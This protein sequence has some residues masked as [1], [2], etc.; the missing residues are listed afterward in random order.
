MNKK[1]EKKKDRQRTNNGDA[2]PQEQQIGHGA[3]ADLDPDYDIFIAESVYPEADQLFRFLPKPFTEI[4]E[5]CLVVLD[6][7]ALLVPYQIGKESLEQ[8]R[9]TYKELVGQKRLVIPAQVAR[10]FA[11]NRSTK[12]AELFQQIS[13]TQE[14][15]CPLD[16]G[17][18]PLLQSMDQYK[19][20]IRLRTEINKQ[21][22][23]YRKTVKSV[24]DIIHDWAWNDPV[25]LLYK[26]LFASD[27]VFGPEVDRTLLRADLAKRFRHKI[28]P[29]YKDGGK[30]DRGIGD[31]LIWYTILELGKKH[32][33]SVVFVSGD[34][35]A[36]WWV[37]SENKLLCPRFELLDEFRR[38][39]EGH[40]FLMMKF[41]NFLSFYGASE[42]I[43]EEVK[44]T[45]KS[46]AQTIVELLDHAMAGE[47][48]GSSHRAGDAK[49][50]VMRWIQKT[51]P[52]R[53]LISDASNILARS[54]LLAVDFLLIDENERITGVEVK[55]VSDL[56]RVS[57]SLPV[58]FN[59]LIPKISE[60]RL[61]EFK[62]WILVIVGESRQAI[63]HLQ[64]YPQALGTRG[65][66]L[67]VVPGYLADSD[68]FEPIG[69]LEFDGG[70]A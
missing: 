34:E 68:T 67:V 10:E 64:P 32:K 42:A 69:V 48:V 51:Y 37:R 49:R 47:S 61:T 41:S 14:K 56:S 19:E 36:D 59:Q 8:I 1:P 21:I 35:K 28:P 13:R 29:G 20:L 55:F 65:L 27:A 63:S 18:Y 24:L 23:E 15:I 26:D 5:D 60:D 31:L 4:K 54:G 58:M 30:P 7:N 43:V 52:Y 46:M 44:S 16:A 6:T 39:S 11:K 38:Y 62:E 33:K 3:E 53:M 57:P 66:K 25:S 45:E 9:K 70:G 2:K 17:Q 12:L 40:S 50:A 22:E